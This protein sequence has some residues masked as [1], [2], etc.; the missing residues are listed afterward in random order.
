MQHLREPDRQTAILIPEDPNCER[1]ELC[2]GLMN[3]ESNTL[4]IAEKKKPIIIPSVALASKE[5]DDIGMLHRAVPPVGM[6]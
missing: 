4:V 1:T 5:E 3:D 2:D 6:L